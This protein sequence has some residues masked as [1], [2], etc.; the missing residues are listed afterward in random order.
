MARDTALAQL[1]EETR[2]LEKISAALAR[3][4]TAA[5]AKEVI[6][7]AAAYEAYAKKAELGAEAER[8]AEAIRLRAE[9]KLG[10]YLRVTPK[11]KGGQPHQRRSTGTKSA[12]V[13]TLASQ[14]IPK[15]LAANAQR[16]AAIP[17]ADFE[18]A[19]RSDNPGRTLNQK[20]RDAHRATLA[21]RA[22]K[23]P[24]GLHRVIYADP[25]WKYGDERTGFT[26][27]HVAAAA[28]YPTMPT[29][30]I[31]AL[32][33]KSL[34]APDAVLFCWAT[35]P[36]VP[37][38]LAVVAAWGFTYKTALVW[39]KGRPNNQGSYHDA[40]GELLLIATRGSCAP[41]VDVRPRQVQEIQRGER[42]SGKPEEFRALIDAMYPSGPR[43]ELFRRGDAP[44]GWATWGNEAAP[45]AVA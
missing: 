28:H 43:I 12:P 7:I 1:N 10:E 45:R 13:E 2:Q 41:E 37:D 20:L 9:R 5:E 38:A 14:G 42:H 40:R 23:L 39:D 6:A 11:A 30:E 32:D 35:F 33:V 29:P 17:A 16:L 26:G 3:I 22:T 27:E 8:Y 21:V 24:A 31:C 18:A 44:A 34:A 19:V 25:P 15:K 36:L 4:S